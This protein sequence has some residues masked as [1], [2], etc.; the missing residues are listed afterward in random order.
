MQR[1]QKVSNDNFLKIIEEIYD[2]EKKYN[3]KAALKFQQ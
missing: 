3:D 1:K 2:V